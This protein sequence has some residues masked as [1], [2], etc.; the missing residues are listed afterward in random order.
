MSYCEEIVR[1]TCVM[2]HS[3]VYASRRV[4][5]LSLPPRIFMVGLLFLDPK[6]KKDADNRQ[7]CGR[8]DA[9]D[10]QP[11][12]GELSSASPQQP[13]PE[14][15]G[16]RCPSHQKW[17]TGSMPMGCCVL[18]C[19]TTRGWQAKRIG[20]SS[21]IILQVPQLPPGDSWRSHADSS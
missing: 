9:K 20:L 4:S 15:L 14:P 18:C 11:K 7:Q 10:Q 6:R 5:I 1:A 19:P 13:R 16:L 21:Y 3:L 8:N 2:S 12:G 17:P